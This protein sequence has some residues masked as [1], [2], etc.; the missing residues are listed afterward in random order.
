MSESDNQRK[1]DLEC[2][3]L[4]ADCRQLASDV[5]NPALQLR[6][7]RMAKVWTGLTEREPTPE[8]EISVKIDG[9]T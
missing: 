8:T 2:L 9:L 3:R 6:F 4:A 1:H 7:R 5:D